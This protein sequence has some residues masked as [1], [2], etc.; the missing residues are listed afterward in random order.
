MFIALQLGGLATR[1]NSPGT[2]H[3][4]M[5][6]AAAC[7]YVQQ[8]A[9]SKLRWAVQVTQ[10]HLHTWHQAMHR[11][12]SLS[13]LLNTKPCCTVS[14]NCS[15]QHYINTGSVS[16]YQAVPQLASKPMAMRNQSHLLYKRYTVF[17]S[18]CTLW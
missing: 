15:Q 9:Q 7:H 4:L 12:F 3:H 14:I 10:H 8:L 17:T 11:V 16:A 18:T 13:S 6:T 5:Q 1:S 2:D